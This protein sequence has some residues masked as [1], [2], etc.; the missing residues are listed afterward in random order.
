VA[1]LRPLA[2][3]G[4]APAQV[5]WAYLLSQGRGTPM[6]RKAD[7]VWLLKAARQGDPRGL[8]IL[9]QMLSTGEGMRKDAQ[10]AYTWAF[11]AQL[12]DPT[13]PDLAP[14]LARV[15]APLSPA[16]RQAAE[17]RARQW[18]PGADLGVVLR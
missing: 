14:L 17:Q 7:K 11:L 8:R 2:E 13:P 9:A 6:D 5:Q 4:F 18:Q 10:L 12:R 3:E 1:L 15:S 16:Q